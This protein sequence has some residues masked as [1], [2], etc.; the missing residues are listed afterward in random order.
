ME[1]EGDGIA[2]AL[3]VAG[4]V[5]EQHRVS[6]PDQEAG[7]PDHI[8]AAT[9]HAMEKQDGATASLARYIPPGNALPGLIAEAD[10]LG[11]Q[12]CWASTHDPMSRSDEQAAD[13]PGSSRSR[14][15]NDR[16]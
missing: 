9:P 8:Q 1:S 6:M 16:D 13:E 3:A 15:G 14:Q 4:E 2:A 10:L 11:V 5:E 7:T 12:V